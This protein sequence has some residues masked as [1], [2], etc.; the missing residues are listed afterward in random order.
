MG[1]NRPTLTCF[2]SRGGHPGANKMINIFGTTIEAPKTDGNQYFECLL[3]EAVKKDSERAVLRQF[4]SPR[5]EE[6]VVGAKK[7]IAGVDVAQL[8]PLAQIHYISQLKL[9]GSYEKMVLAT[10]NS[11]I[12]RRLLQGKHPP[13]PSTFPRDHK[14]AESLVVGT[15]SSSI[16]ERECREYLAYKK[17]KSRIQDIAQDMFFAVNNGLT[18]EQTQNYLSVIY[19]L[20]KLKTAEFTNYPQIRQNILKS[21][22]TNQTLELA[23]MK[24]LRFTFPHGNRLSLLEHTDDAIV[25][26]KN[27][28]TH[29]PKSESKLFDRLEN[30]LSIF[31]K[32]KLNIKLTILV[33]D[34]EI[35][36]YFPDSNTFGM[37]P[38]VDLANVHRSLHKYLCAV[39]QRFPIHQVLFL[40]EHLS[41]NN[42]LSTY[43]QTRSNILHNL[44]TGKS[45]YP[46]NFVESR[47]DYRYESNSRIFTNPPD[48]MVAR[49]QINGVLASMAALCVLGSKYILIEDDR[50]DENNYIG[51]HGKSA[52]P[53]IFCKLRD[54]AN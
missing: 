39:K 38:R 2:Q 54:K 7:A 13:L 51:G 10:M 4:L 31:I 34:Q 35:N 1:R 33:S 48:R 6:I 3:T 53:V 42:M 41:N 43:D 22:K 52:I 25:V 47:V 46:E 45:I 11:P 18:S 50:G 30:I 23:H 32:S 17:V 21:I 26:T 5:F 19:E 24:C 15:V 29:H 44:S 12:S 28:E 40:R 20:E 27:N 8:K 14:L 49:V 16:G 37:L 9:S 36:D